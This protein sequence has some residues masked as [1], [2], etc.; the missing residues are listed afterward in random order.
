MTVVKGFA[1]ARVSLGTRMLAK[2]CAQYAFLILA[3]VAVLS[4]IYQYVSRWTVSPTATNTISVR[5]DLIVKKAEG[6]DI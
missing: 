2:N 4:A 3:V 6:F 1:D 5:H